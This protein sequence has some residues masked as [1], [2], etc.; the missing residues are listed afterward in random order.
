M[1]RNIHPAA[2]ARLSHFMSLRGEVKSRD[3]LAT[4]ESAICDRAPAQTTST[5]V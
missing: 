3:D 4:P 5:A 1:E 2:T